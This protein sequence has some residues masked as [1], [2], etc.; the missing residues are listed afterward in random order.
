L[1]PISVG[2]EHYLMKE[3]IRKKKKKEGIAIIPA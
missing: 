1:K 3:M 2:I